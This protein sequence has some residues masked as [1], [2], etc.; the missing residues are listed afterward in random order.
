MA[1]VAVAIGILGVLGYAEIPFF[2]YYP[3]FTDTVLISE[4]IDMLLFVGASL[5]VPLS[6]LVFALQLGARRQSRGDAG[7]TLVVVL[8]VSLLSL[9]FMDMANVI[10]PHSN[11]YGKPDHDLVIWQLWEHPTKSHQ[12][13]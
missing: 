5:C 4:S 2:V 1:G 7:V 10:R 11:G 6:V 9:I 13:D 12:A 8:A 3:R